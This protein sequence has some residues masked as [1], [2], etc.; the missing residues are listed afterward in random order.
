[1]RIPSFIAACH[2]VPIQGA[3]RDQSTEHPRRKTV[4]VPWCQRRYGQGWRRT[5]M[6]IDLICAPEV[7]DA[8]GARYVHNGGYARASADQR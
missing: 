8:T 1:M 7:I 5:A 3:G 6:P 2:N 4:R